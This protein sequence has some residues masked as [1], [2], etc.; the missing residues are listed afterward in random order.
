MLRVGLDMFLRTLTGIYG[1]S[2]QWSEG[3]EAPAFGCAGLVVVAV[4]VI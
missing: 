2:G 1:Q 3:G 4:S